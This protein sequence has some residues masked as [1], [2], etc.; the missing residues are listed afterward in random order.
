MR[1]L[2]TCRLRARKRRRWWRGRDGVRVGLAIVVLGP[3]RIGVVMLGVRRRGVRRRQRCRKSIDRADERF[4]EAVAG[5][6][7]G[8]RAWRG[9]GGGTELPEVPQR[10]G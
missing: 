4:S 5:E 9:G 1:V 6:R 2:I 8:T 3:A 7:S 10:T